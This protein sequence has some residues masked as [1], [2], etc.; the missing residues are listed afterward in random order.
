MGRD[1]DWRV[2]MATTFHSFM[3]DGGVP[4]ILEQRIP[5]TTVE[6]HRGRIPLARNE[7]SI[8]TGF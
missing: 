2:H 5:E 1:G 7:Q 3:S 8:R 4:L 6:A